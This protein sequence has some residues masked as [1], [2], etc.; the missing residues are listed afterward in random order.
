MNSKHTF[1]PP[2]LTF[3]SVVSVSLLIAGCTSS[4]TSSTINAT[5]NNAAVT[6]ASKP[7][8]NLKTD[9]FDSDESFWECAINEYSTDFQQIRDGN[10][11]FQY[12]VVDGIIASCK[13]TDNGKVKL[14]VGYQMGDGSYQFFEDYVDT[15]KSS[16]RYGADL[17]NTLL[18]NDTVRVCVWVINSDF[19]DYGNLVAIQKTGHT[20]NFV[21]EYIANAESE[22]VTDQS[23]NSNSTDSR[24]KNATI[25]TADV[26][27]GTSTEVIGQRAYIILPKDALK[28]ITAEGYS[29]FVSSAVKDSGYNWFSI[30]CDDGTGINFAG[31]S[32]AFATYGEMDSEGS[33]TD[34]IGYISL[35]EDGYVYES[36][37]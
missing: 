27:N 5:V 25:F 20:D 10:I 14:V 7:N 18:T 15:T 24:L 9:F 1:T 36:I 30:I 35:T 29:Q 37:K 6:E 34:P 26:Y 3:A 12:V 19:L 31:C 4:D 32:S 33:I 11:K 2:P 8:I 13:Y 16:I 28:E 21:Q 17:F 22:S 23:S